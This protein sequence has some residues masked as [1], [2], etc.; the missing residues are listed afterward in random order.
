MPDMRARIQEFHSVLCSD[1]HVPQAHSIDQRLQHHVALLSMA[2]DG[3]NTVQ[4]SCL[5][6]RDRI[7]A[8]NC[9]RQSLCP[10]LSIIKAT[11][12]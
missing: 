5:R 10:R 6:D 9:P 3:A 4:I 1:Q 11:A 2:S 8:T 12:R 7:D